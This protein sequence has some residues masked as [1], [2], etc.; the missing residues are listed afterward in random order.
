MKKRVFCLISFLLITMLTIYQNLQVYNASEV[1]FAT[2]YSSGEFIKGNI[3][4]V[5][6]QF[7]STGF[8]FE[9]TNLKFLE[10]LDAKKVYSSTTCGVENIYYY[11]SK[12]AKFELIKKRRVNIHVAKNG[13][14]VKVGVPL[15]Y[16][17][18]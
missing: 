13:N 6:S 3:L 11:S 8:S 7:S 9:T 10:K 18:Y 1:V 17:G 2:S 16:Y 4:E 15:I 12:I 14:I 5:S